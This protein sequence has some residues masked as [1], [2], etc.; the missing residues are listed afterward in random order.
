MKEEDRRSMIRLGN[1]GLLLAPLLLVTGTSCVLGL[2]LAAVT[3][4]DYSGC[5]GF[6]PQVVSDT[7]YATGQADLETDGQPKVCELMAGD[8]SD[9]VGAC[10]GF[11]NP[12]R[13]WMWRGKIEGY[14]LQAGVA[15]QC[16]FAQGAQISLEANL[17][18]PI[19]LALGEQDLRVGVARYPDL[20]GAACIVENLPVHVRVTE[21]AGQSAPWPMLVTPD[22]VRSFSVEMEIHEARGIRYRAGGAP[23]CKRTVTARTKAV[24]HE[25]AADLHYDPKHRCECVG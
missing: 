7:R 23:P 4:A 24:F 25:T 16:I 21:A 15:V 2:G 10:R 1:P 9:Q 19:S 13:Q 20:D 17:G 22:Y 3:A 6:C 18:D 11:M 12:V 14:P 8:L 5:Q